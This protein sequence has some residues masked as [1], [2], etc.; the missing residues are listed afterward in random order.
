VITLI[1]E[2]TGKRLRKFRREKCDCSYEYQYANAK[3]FNIRTYSN[4]KQFNS[5]ILNEHI[6][7]KTQFLTFFISFRLII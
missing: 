4:K 3:L 6:K 1:N 7:M 5:S 2:E